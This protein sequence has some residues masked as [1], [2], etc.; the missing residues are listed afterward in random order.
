MAPVVQPSKS[1][2]CATAVEKWA[3]RAKRVNQSEVA[4]MMRVPVWRV[5]PAFECVLI[6]INGYGFLLTVCVFTSTIAGT[7]AVRFTH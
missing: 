5:L 3:V 1:A 4:C 7:F 2:A 6:L